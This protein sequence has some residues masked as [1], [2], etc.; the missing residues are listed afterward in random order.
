MNK[1]MQRNY[2]TSFVGVLNFIKDGWEF[3]NN[4]C[5]IY[6]EDIGL[7]IEYSDKNQA[8]FFDLGIK[9]RDGK[10]QDG[11]LNKRDF[12]PFSIAGKFLISQV[13]YHLL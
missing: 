1:V 13:I 2:F 8:S 4:Y 7:G 9:I 10:F 11:L 12:L 3:D 5:N 6:P